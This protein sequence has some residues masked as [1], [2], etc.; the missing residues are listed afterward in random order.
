MSFQ[1]SVS[2]RIRGTDRVKNMLVSG[3]EKVAV[4]GSRRFR[5][6]VRH[7]ARTTVQVSVWGRVRIGFRDRFSGKVRESIQFKARPSF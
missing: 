3:Q 6:E 5:V 4:G 7:S 2:G 1:G